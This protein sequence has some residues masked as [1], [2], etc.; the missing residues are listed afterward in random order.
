MSDRD[1]HP[2]EIIALQDLPW[3]ARVRRLASLSI[4]GKF[5]YLP[6]ALKDKDI[7]KI[8]ER[9]NEPWGKRER[10]RKELK[11]EIS[12]Q[13]KIRQ[14]RKSRHRK[15]TCCLLRNYSVDIAMYGGWTREIR[16]TALVLKRIG[17][18]YKP[19]DR[20]I[21]WSLSR[22]PAYG[23]MDSRLSGNAAF[24]LAMPSAVW[25]GH[26]WS[27]NEEQHKVRYL[28]FNVDGVGGNV[29]VPITCKTV[30]EAIQALKRTSVLTAEKKSC[31]V[32]ID[33]KNRCFRVKSPRRKSWREIP[34]KES[35]KGA[36]K[37][38]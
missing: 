9:V 20:R 14:E 12:R 19:L 36:K 15:L 27:Y 23:V 2:L 16:R 18:S 3:E 33:W 31:A 26:C 35:R 28:L 1:W 11:T 21:N 24:A 5:G 6:S 17:K 32:E 37:R 38:R 29:R 4:T 8:V 34:F 22:I 13:R 30:A 10:L 7:T 25:I